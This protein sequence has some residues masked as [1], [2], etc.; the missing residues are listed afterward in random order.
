MT[1]QMGNWNPNSIVEGSIE[2]KCSQ[3]QIPIFV[4][5]SGQ[6]ML[7]EQQ[8]DAICMQCFKKIEDPEIKVEVTKESVQEALNHLKKGKND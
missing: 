7:T 3:C 5:K 6:K 8:A 1:V 4:S 2:K